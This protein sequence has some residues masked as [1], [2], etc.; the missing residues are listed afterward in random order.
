MA[1]GRDGLHKRE[2]NILAFRYKAA[3]GRW[4]EKYTGKTK[5]QEAR[6]F[7]MDFEAKL[8]AGELPNEKAN[9][10]VEQAAKRWVEQ[11]AARLT[12]EKAKK[13]EKSFL[14]QLTKRLGARKLKSITL[15]DLKDYQRARREQVRERPINL[16]LKILV[17]VL[18]E[19]NLWRPIGEHYKR[20]KEPESDIGQA[21]TLA[22]LQQIEK[23]AATKDAWRVA[24]YAEVLAANTGLRGGEIKKLK[25]GAIDLEARRIRIAR[26]DTKSNAGARLI[27]LNQGAIEAVCKLYVRAQ[28]LGAT[29]PEHYLLPAD[30]SR[31]TKK[32]DPLKGGR[33]F[34][35]ARHQVSWDTAWRSLRKAAAGAIG[36]AAKK[37]QRELAADERETIALFEALRFHDLRHTFISLMGERG[38]PIQIVQAMVGHMSGAMVRYYTHISNRAAREAVELLDKPQ[39]SSFVGNFVGKEENRQSAVSKR[40]N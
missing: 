24:Y 37:E 10:T 11:H 22:Q 38:V 15:D 26:K 39:V 28:S 1:K 21:L 6:D 8:K 17:S 35:V 40:L 9:Q 16:E 33:G 31:H 12:S 23:M 32:T 18:K 13:N 5:R 27:E 7:K 14:N 30:L 2:G 25:L 4:K 20:L 3:D 19:A 36:D 29:E 34:D